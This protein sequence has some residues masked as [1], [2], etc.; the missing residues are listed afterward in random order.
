VKVNEKEGDRKAEKARE[1]HRVRVSERVCVWERD[2][3]NYHRVGVLYSFRFK[4]RSGVKFCCAC[5][6]VCCSALQYVVVHCSVWQCVAVCCSVFVC[7]CVSGR[8]EERLI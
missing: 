3:K 1:R 4:F 6:A 2:I 7:V 5:V 8:L